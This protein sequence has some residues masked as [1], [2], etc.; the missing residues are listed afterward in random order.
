M[1]GKEL[2]RGIWVD[3]ERGSNFFT[4]NFHFRSV[5]PLFHLSTGDMTGSL[6]AFGLNKIW[7]LWGLKLLSLLCVI[8]GLLAGG[9]PGFRT[10]LYWFCSH[11]PGY[12]NRVMWCSVLLVCVFC[13]ANSGDDA[14]HHP[15]HS[16][17]IANSSPVKCP[18]FCLVCC[19]CCLF[20]LLFVVLVLFLW[21]APWWFSVAVQAFVQAVFCNP[22]L[23]RGINLNSDI[24]N[25]SV[26]YSVLNDLARAKRLT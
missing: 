15:S 5:S 18:L 14:C 22:L 19:F 10:V 21:L 24:K 26:Q 8:S 12:G 1:L 11:R 17:D 16:A 9:S 23:W 3:T 25:Y 4:P 6:L 20:L 13:H 2:L 7:K